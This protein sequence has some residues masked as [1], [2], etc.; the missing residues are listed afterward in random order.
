M[1]ASAFAPT[2]VDALSIDRLFV[3]MTVSAVVV[4][5]IVAALTVWCFRWPATAD[6]RRRSMWL[7]VGGGAVFPAVVLAALLAFA[8]PMIPALT[9]EAPA[10]RSLHARVH[11][12]QWWWRVDYVRDGQT[13]ATLANELRIPVGARLPIQLSSEDVVHSFWVPSLAGKVDTIPGRITYAA[14]EATTTGRHLGQCA[15]F[16]GTAHARMAIVV[17]AMEPAAFEM[18]LTE[19]GMAATVDDGDAGA[20]AFRRSGCAGCHAIRGTDARGTIGPDLTHVGRRVR[21]GAGILPN[22]SA[23]RKA[24]IENPARHKPGVRM[25]PFGGLGADV[26]IIVDYLARLR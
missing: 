19:E 26:D 3:I 18:W 17:E 25:P 21:L 1:H 15:E 10:D 5:L 11:A 23:Q 9:A 14:L 2:G 7:I 4:W 13:I 8:L 12:E 16:C 20:A 24:W 22:D 6:A